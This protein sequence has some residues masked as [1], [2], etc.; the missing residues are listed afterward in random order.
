LFGADERGR[1]TVDV[2]QSGW[3]T[4]CEALPGS[5]VEELDVADVGMGVT[6]VT[7]LA[8]AISSMAALEVLAVGANPIGSEGGSALLEAVKTSNLKI[9]DIGKPLPIQAP[10]ESQTLDLSET[11]MGPGQAVIL[12]WWLATPFSAVL[13]SVNVLKNPIGD[14]GLATLAA[15]VQAS[16]LGSICG[17]VEGQTSVDWSEQNLGPFDCKI[18]AADFGLGTWEL[19]PFGTNIL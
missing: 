5:S 8:K 17:L 3:S 19:L 16:S 9:I 18:I 10:Y 11:E 6:G 15:A 4:L 13:A 1:H 2:D 7:S 14:D 12:S